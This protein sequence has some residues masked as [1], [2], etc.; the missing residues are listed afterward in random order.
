MQIIISVKFDKFTMFFDKFLNNYLGGNDA[1]CIR[2]QGNSAMARVPRDDR[3]CG[4][5]RI[6]H[7]TAAERPV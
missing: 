1:R 4:E 2:A 6:T 7:L 5:M 3:N